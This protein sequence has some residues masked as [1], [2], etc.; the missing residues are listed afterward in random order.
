MVGGSGPR[1]SHRGSEI[2]KGLFEK[3]PQEYGGA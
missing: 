3:K 2:G 1:A